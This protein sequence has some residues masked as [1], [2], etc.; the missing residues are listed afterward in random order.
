MLTCCIGRF[1]KLIFSCAIC[2]LILVAIVYS[3]LQPVLP[4]FNVSEWNF[5]EVDFTFRKRVELA[6]LPVD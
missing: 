2:L 6:G 1:V 4:E 5:T 3:S